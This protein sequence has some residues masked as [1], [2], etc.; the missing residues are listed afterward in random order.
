MMN[1][2]AVAN[3]RHYEKRL[4]MRSLWSANEQRLFRED[5]QAG[6]A[7]TLADWQTEANFRRI[8][9]VIGGCPFTARMMKQ[10]GW[11]LNLR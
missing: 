7:G 8:E 10:R 9:N 6:F 2:F 11:N 5:K 1:G 4:V 3:R